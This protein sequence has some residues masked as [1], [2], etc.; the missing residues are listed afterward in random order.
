[1]R[2]EEMISKDELFQ[3]LNKLP[4]LKSLLTQQCLEASVLKSSRHTRASSYTVT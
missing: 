3:F 2:I 4:Q 1:M